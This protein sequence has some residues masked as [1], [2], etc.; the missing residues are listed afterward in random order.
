MSKRFIFEQDFGIFHHTVIVCHGYSDAQIKQWARRKYKGETEYL[1]LIDAAVDSND[2]DN[3]SARTLLSK[4]DDGTF[5]LPRVLLFKYKPDRSIGFIMTLIHE[6]MHMVDTLSTD[7]GFKDE[8]EAR[9]YLMEY[10]VSEIRKK[11]LDKS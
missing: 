11:C 1:R 8:L 4:R 9:A 2:G 6:C 3:F 7:H 10:L 5:V